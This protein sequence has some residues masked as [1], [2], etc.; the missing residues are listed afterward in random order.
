MPKLPPDLSRPSEII[1]DYLDTL[2]DSCIKDDR[3]RLQVRKKEWKQ[4]NKFAN[5][6]VKPIINGTKSNNTKV[7]TYR[8][9][10]IMT[11]SMTQ[12]TTQTLQESN[13]VTETRTG[14]KVSCSNI[15]CGYQ[16]IMHTGPDKF[17]CN[18]PRCHKRFR[19]FWK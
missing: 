12:S 18:C 1:D 5:V 14:Y 9:T 15:N 17:Y 7:T 19:I 10:S 8:P 2:K 13:K 4:L 11:T 3:I 6:S 16:W